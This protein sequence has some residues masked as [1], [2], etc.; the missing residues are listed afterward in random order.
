[1]QRGVVS[2]S[3]AGLCRAAIQYNARAGM[4]PA[5]EEQVN[6][7]VRGAVLAAA[8]IAAPAAL[9]QQPLIYPSKGQ[10]ADQ[11][12]KDQGECYVWAKQQTGVDPAA[13]AQTASSQPAPTGPQGERVRGA[14]RGAAAGAVIGEVANDDAGKGAATGAVVGTM[15]G[16]SRQRRNARGQEQQQQQVQQQSQQALAT[17]N[18]AFSACMEGRG[19]VVK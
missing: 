9:A 18:R 14:A 3:G 11:Q 16:G 7:S 5:Q 10:S 17:Y 6:R 4:Q 19:Y 8:L 13:V 12:N 1:V 2:P 15:A